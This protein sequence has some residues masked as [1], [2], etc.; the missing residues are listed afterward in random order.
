VSGKKR[1]RSTVE[2][3]MKSVAVETA[4]NS[5]VDYMERRGYEEFKIVTREFNQRGYIGVSFKPNP[6]TIYGFIAEL[7]YNWAGDNILRERVQDEVRTLVR[8]KQIEKN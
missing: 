4:A 2:K 3:K 1:K 7:L 5:I 6:D 8:E